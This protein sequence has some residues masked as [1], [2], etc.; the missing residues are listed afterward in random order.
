METK[1]AILA[2]VLLVGCLGPAC[3]QKDANQP[4]AVEKITIGT[5]LIGMSGLIYI[6]KDKGYDRDQGLEVSIKDYQAG[7]DA[8]REVRAGGLDFACC[9]E[10]VLVNEV[11]IGAANLRCLAALSSGDI[12]AL[13]ARRDKGISRPKDLR[14]KTIGVSIGTSGEFFL[15][16]FLAFNNISLK[17]VTIV[18]LNPFDWPNALVV[19]KVDAI[20]AWE[21]ATYEII[22]KLAN[23]A[24]EWPAQEGQNF[25]WL[26]VSREDIIK[27]KR[28]ALEKLLRTLAQAAEFIKEQP[29]ATKE[30]IAHWTKVPLADLQSSNYP[31]RFELALDQGLLLA[32]EDE[33]RWMI[34]NRLTNATMV[35]NYLPYFD[36]A[37]LSKVKLEAV[38]IIIPPK[39]QKFN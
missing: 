14:G 17:E 31:K 39:D 35:P 22:N 15:G 1:T 23:N 9:S 29:E 13:I 5:N 4:R 10:F 37:P 28:G 30:I 12:H 7:R 26:L 19:G 34:K 36:V 27:N 11:L 18:D 38:N 24:L 20:L 16:R 2:L 6:A 3:S 21:P 8:V 33:T 25:Y 32:M